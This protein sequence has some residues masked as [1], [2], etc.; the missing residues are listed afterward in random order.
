MPPREKRPGQK[1][2][3]KPGIFTWNKIWRGAEKRTAMQ[4]FSL[5]EVVSLRELVI[6]YML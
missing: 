1:K 5:R 2:K 3:K 6:F 4:C